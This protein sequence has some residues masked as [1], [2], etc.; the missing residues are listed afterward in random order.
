MQLT[1]IATVLVV[2]MVGVTTALPYDF[3]SFK[4]FY[5]GGDKAAAAKKP[6]Q[7]AAVTKPPAQP[8]AVT[9]PPAQPANK[10]GFLGNF[11]FKNIG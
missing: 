2:G 4:P 11:R 5:I 10:G 9:K 8:A 1:K 6:A 3:G 7:P